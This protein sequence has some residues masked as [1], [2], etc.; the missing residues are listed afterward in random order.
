M[1]GFFGLQAGFDQ[2]D[3]DAAG[4]GLLIFGEGEDAF[5]YTGW[6]RD[7]LADGIVN[8]WHG[9]ILPQNFDVWMDR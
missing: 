5:G 6:E 9:S 4:A 2:V 8:V 7:A 1:L 3:E